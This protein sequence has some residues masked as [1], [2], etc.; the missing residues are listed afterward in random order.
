V[1]DFV[2]QRYF[3]QLTAL[4]QARRVLTRERTMVVSPEA[5]STPSAR[6]KMLIELG[7][8][9]TMI[10]TYG[11]ILP[12]NAGAMA[13]LLDA[14]QTRISVFSQNNGDPTTNA[15]VLN[16]LQV[17]ADTYAST[18]NTLLDTVD[19]TL[20]ANTATAQTAALRETT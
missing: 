3:L 20:D 9:S 15:A 11:M 13:S 14:V 1:E 10:K 4:H 6:A 17:S 8:E 2:V 19:R 7:S 16:T 5:T 12:E 18:I